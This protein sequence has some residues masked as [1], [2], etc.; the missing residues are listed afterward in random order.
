[1]TELRD[2]RAG[3]SLCAYDLRRATEAAARA[4]YAWIGRGD[5]SQGDA[6]AIAAMEAELTALGFDGQVLIGEGPRSETSQLYH[7]QRFG[8]PGRIPLWDIA[9]DPVEGTSFLAKGMTNAMAC[10]AVAPAGSLFDPGPAFY[11]EKFVAP[12]AAKGRIDPA[13]AVE[14]KMAMLAQCLGKPVEDLTV[15]VLEKPRHRDLVERIHATGARVALYPAGDVAGALMAAIPGSGI[16]ALMGTG[17]CPEGMLSACAIKVLGGEFS[18]RIDPQLATE[19]RAVETAGMDLDRWWSVD[20]LVRSDDVT[21]CATGITTG[22]LFEGI[23]RTA[24]HERTQTLMVGGGA[25]ERQLLTS[26]HRRGP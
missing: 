20:D 1:M 10:I 25:G 6:A 12:P 22:L 3:Q 2:V 9:A 21:F 11:M 13:A 16:D 24:T 7:G 15:Y 8:D 23:E 17:G 26:W 14:A 5:K 4:A 19:R 18:A